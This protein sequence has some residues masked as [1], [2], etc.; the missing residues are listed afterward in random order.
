MLSLQSNIGIILHAIGEYDHSLRF[1]EHA[2][3]INLKIHGKMS[4]KTALSYHLV[5]RTLSCMGDFRGALNHEKETFLIYKNELGERH[6]KTKES[7]DCLKHLTSQAV[8]LQKKINE[9][10]QGNSNALI[11]PIQIQP[12]TLSSLID[13]LNVVN[14]LL[15][16]TVSPEYQLANESQS[17]EPKLQGEA[18]GTLEIDQNGLETD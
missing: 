9:I 18:S 11:P 6:D 4:L 12:P 10:Y 17:D 15:F 8:V 7:S 16:V 5:A 14:G 3:K 13:I 1:V 2:L